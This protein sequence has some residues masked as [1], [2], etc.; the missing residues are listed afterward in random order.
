MCR[1]CE[2]GSELS[3]FSHRSRFSHE[4]MEHKCGQRRQKTQN[5]WSH[6]E[7]SSL[8]SGL[9]ELFSSVMATQPELSHGWFYNGKAAETSACLKLPSFKLYIHKTLRTEML[10][11]NTSW[12]LYKHDIKKVWQSQSHCPEELLS[13]GGLLG[14]LAGPHSSCCSKRLPCPA[15]ITVAPFPSD[16]PASNREI[17]TQISALGPAFPGY[18]LTELWQTSFHINGVSLFPK[19]QQQH[20]KFGPKWLKVITS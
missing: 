17:L 8:C 5:S 9:W 16:S 11:W 2:C 20:L 3:L 15:G 6:S 19:Q 13:S 14:S 18:I 12:L 4:F 1:V 7:G 10:N